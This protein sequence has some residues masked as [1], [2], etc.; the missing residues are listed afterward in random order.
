MA[1]DTST[2]VRAG[3]PDTS[4][5]AAESQL[6]HLSVLQGHVLTLF[7]EAELGLTDSELDELYAGVRAARGWK[8]VRFE[9]PR[10]RRSDLTSL[11]RLVD[12]GFRRLNPYG[13][14][15]VVWFYVAGE[16]I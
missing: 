6:P 9:T 12:S 5:L 4:R 7:M 13:R 11:G 10:K 3:D 15:E 1:N 14:P 8:A 16:V 2:L